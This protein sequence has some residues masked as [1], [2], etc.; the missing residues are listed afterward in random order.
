[1]ISSATVLIY[2]TKKKKVISL[3]PIKYEFWNKTYAVFHLNN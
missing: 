3:E 1:M 2:D